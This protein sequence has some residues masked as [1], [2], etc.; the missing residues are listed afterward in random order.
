[1]HVHGTGTAMELARKI[2]PAIDLMGTFPARYASTVQAQSD[3]VAG[4]FD[5]ATLDSIVGTKGSALAGG[6]YKYTLGRSDLVLKEMG[7][8]INSRMGLNS[9]ASLFGSDANAVVAGDIAMLSHE[10][11]PVMKALRANGI[12]I[13]AVHNH[14]TSS[15]PAVYFL[16]YWGKGKAED[17]ARGFKAGLDATGKPAP[18]TGHGG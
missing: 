14:M 13:V 10:L 5:T 2:K 6:T 9:W 3:V 7:A 15:A 16:H 1:M 18:M 8:V 17:L 11:T 4:T 12:E